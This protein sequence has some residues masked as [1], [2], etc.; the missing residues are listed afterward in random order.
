MSDVRDKRGPRT[1]QYHPVGNAVPP[2]LAQ[3]G[4]EIRRRGVRFH[5]GRPMMADM[6]T[7]ERRS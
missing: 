1:A 3:Q 5:P 4:A 6:L 7:S 2:K